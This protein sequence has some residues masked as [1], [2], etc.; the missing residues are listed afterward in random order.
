MLRS[1][2]NAIQRLMWDGDA[3]R[4]FLACP[5]GVT[6]SDLSISLKKL[7]SSREIAGIEESAYYR[8]ASCSRALAELFVNGS[9][10]LN[11][12]GGLSYIETLLKG[13]LNVST[14]TAAT[15]SLF[16]GYILAPEAIRVAASF[17]FAENASWI[18]YLLEYEWAVWHSQRCALGW[19]PLV[20]PLEGFARSVF[21]LQVPFELQAL[22]D[23]VARMKAASVPEEV[24]RWRCKPNFSQSTY[25]L[26][27]Y[28]SNNVASIELSPYAYANLAES[29]QGANT[30]DSDLAELLH[31]HGLI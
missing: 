11:S 23:D 30:L 31:E 6:V 2:Y 29:I 20:A 26:V 15:Y 3:R 17:D 13:Y 7:L 27:S 1:D 9:V 10:L 24:Y 4:R 8:I 19:E 25:L 22:L 28:T 16:D 21:L 5:Q 12:F 14:P 18:A